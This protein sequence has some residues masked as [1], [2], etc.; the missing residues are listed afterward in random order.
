[1]SQNNKKECQ[2]KNIDNITS[3][4]KTP[5]TLSL[6]ENIEIIEEM[7]TDCDDIKKRTMSLGKGAD[8]KACIF[9]VEVVVNNI[10]IEES[11]IG[12]LLSRLMGMDRQEI[13]D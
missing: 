5:L 3:H 8:V 12:K 9:Y 2:N 4:T 7:F 11:V 10:T 6:D 13:Y 1:M